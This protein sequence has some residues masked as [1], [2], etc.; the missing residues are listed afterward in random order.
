MQTLKTI[1]V[2]AVLAIAATGTASAAGKCSQKAFG[3]VWLVSSSGGQLCLL[4]VSSK[5]DIT[6]SRC[7]LV[8][9]LDSAVGSLSGNIG[10]A[11]NCKVSGE[12]T[13]KLGKK[14]EKLTISGRAAVAK[15]T[16]VIEAKGT[17]KSGT[18]A[19]AGLQQ[20]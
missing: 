11:S 18:V 6:E 2:A 19:L 16:N 4:E 13:Q 12:I 1:A 20:W 10:I 9:R 8:E 15:G 5:G 3:G 14:S 7:Y 17:S